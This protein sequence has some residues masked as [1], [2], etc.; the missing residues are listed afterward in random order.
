[1]NMGN[2]VPF[3]EPIPEADILRCTSCGATTKAPCQCGVP[4]AL[5]KPS[6]AAKIAIQQ[7]PNLTD[8]AIA[9]RIGVTHPT[10]ADARVTDVRDQVVK[11]LPP[12]YRVGLDGKEY[13]AS[14]KYRMPPKP[15]RG[16][17]PVLTK[18]LSVN[19][20]LVAVFDSI[21]TKGWSDYQLALFVHA[22]QKLHER[23]KGSVQWYDAVQRR[24]EAKREAKR[25]KEK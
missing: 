3:Q 7:T 11:N 25:N 5:L 24:K 12:A 6:E 2:I 16:C 23:A 9:K 21:V 10:V 20:A 13:P 8:R 19:E 4:F 14:R 17:D 1:M 18:D 22:C 15:K